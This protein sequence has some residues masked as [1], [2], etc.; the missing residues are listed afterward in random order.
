MLSPK[1]IQ[2]FFGSLDVDCRVKDGGG[3]CAI[4]FCLCGE[5]LWIDA[6]VAG[7][8]VEL[9]GWASGGRD[10]RSVA[11]GV[12]AGCSA[13]PREWAG[14]DISTASAPDS[15]RAGLSRPGRGG[16]AGEAD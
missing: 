4:D 5:E 13:R 8:A 14:E 2:H 6:A 10:S 3:D 9:S 1:Q 15:W 16:V 12:F 7:N 11:G